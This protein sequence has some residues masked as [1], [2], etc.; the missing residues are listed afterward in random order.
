MINLLFGISLSKA[1]KVTVS[2]DV[3]GKS[4]YT[5]E[6]TT[7][8][9]IGTGTSASN[10][11]YCFLP[12]GFPAISPVV[13]GGNN[14]DPYV[15][16]KVNGVAYPC[17]ASFGTLGG[18]WDTGVQLSVT[19]ASTGITIP[20]GSK[21]QITISGLIKN[22][23]NPGNYTIQ[24]RTSTITGQ[25][26]QDF[27]SNVSVSGTLATEEIKIKQNEFSVYPNPAIDFIQVSGVKKLQKY[28]VYNT[29]GNQIAEGNISENGKINIHHFV[30]GVY[31]LK[32]ENGKSVQFIRK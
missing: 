24:W 18:S 21:I 25:V 23:V 17:S 9:A 15:S 20:A 3:M 27:S 32:L 1:Q 5:F 28:T 11:F 22:P 6:Y 2:N 7:S 8:G 19:G 16:F 4:V 26:I 13:Q 29:V 14:L 12:A 31:F 30:S 10:V